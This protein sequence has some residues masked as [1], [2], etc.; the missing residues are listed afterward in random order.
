MTG[1]GLPADTFD[2]II[3]TQTLQLIYEVPTA[4]RNLHRCL[5][6]EGVLLGTMPGMSP[7]PASDRERWGWHWGFTTSSVR[8][9]CADHFH[10]GESTVEAYGN[11]LSAISFLHGL[12]AEELTQQELDVRSPAYELLITVRAEKGA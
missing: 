4:I 2:C 1:D 11:V 8:R 9:L 3:C 7:I 6:P 10:P 12:A 5:R